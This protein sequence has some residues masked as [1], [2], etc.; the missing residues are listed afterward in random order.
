MK[1]Y[2]QKTK[3]H[4]PP[5]SL[6]SIW[7]GAGSSRCLHSNNTQHSPLF[8]SHNHHL[9]SPMPKVHKETCFFICSHLPDFNL[10]KKKVAHSKSASTTRRRNVTH[11]NLLS[12]FY[13]ILACAMSAPTILKNECDLANRR[14]RKANIEKC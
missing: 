13:R 6:S 14:D 3:N 5:W 10:P 8:N 7:G 1:G 4:K 12:I 2:S 9:L 11:Y